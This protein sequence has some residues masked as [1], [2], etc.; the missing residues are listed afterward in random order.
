M[1]TLSKHFTLAEL[2]ISQEAARRGLD[3]TPGPGVQKNLVRLCTDYL[4][5]VRTAMKR[6]LIVSSGYRSA[7]LN[8]LVGGSATSAHVDGRAADFIVP[9]MTLIDVFDA[10]AK[11][12]VEFDQLIFEYGRWIHLGIA[13]AGKAPRRDTL[14]K[15]ATT[16]YEKYDRKSAAAHP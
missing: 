15:F 1:T 7:V 4:E 6:P 16:A 8:Q 5:P 2:T 13:P 12:A 3:N 11:S 9:G 10:I 14:M